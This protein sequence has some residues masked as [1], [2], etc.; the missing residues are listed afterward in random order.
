MIS[1]QFSDK[2]VSYDT[3][4]DDLATRIAHR[5]QQSKQDP[6]TVSQRKAFLMFGRANVERWRRKCMIEPC[7]HG[8][9]LEY[10]TADLRLLQQIKQDYL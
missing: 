5:M 4:M 3:F 6:E 1:I 2:M 10:R 8:G 9:K 7:K